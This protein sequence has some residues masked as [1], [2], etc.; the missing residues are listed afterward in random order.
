LFDPGKSVHILPYGL[1][2]AAEVSRIRS[3]RAPLAIGYLG[4]LLPHKGVHVLIESFQKID[5]SLAELHVWGAS[6]DEK[7][8]A[9]LREMSRR[10][11]HVYLHG[12]LAE[13]NKLETIRRFDVLVVPS[14]GWESFGIVAREAMAVGVPVIAS[15][16]SALGELFDDGAGG[17]HVV[18]GDANAIASLINELAASPE[19]LAEWRARLPRVRSMAEHA[20]EID[21]I[22]AELMPQRPDTP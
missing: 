18:P 11:P 1:P 16:I 5:P 4:A 12:A 10:L 20:A 6:G 3:P 8:V 22:Y 9:R 7:Y 13:E 2:I 19:R 15:R 17:A 14:V 21:H